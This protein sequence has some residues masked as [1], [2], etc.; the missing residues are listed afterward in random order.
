MTKLPMKMWAV[1][2]LFG[3]Y[4]PSIHYTRRAAMRERSEWSDLQDAKF[5]IVRVEITEV[6][7]S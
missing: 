1:I 4:L 6:K 5:K 2:D 7:R 3:K